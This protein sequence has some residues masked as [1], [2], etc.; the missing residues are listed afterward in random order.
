MALRIRRGTNSER[1]SIVPLEGELI[2]TTDTKDLYVGDGNTLGGVAVADMGISTL[3]QSNLVA[4]ISTY[5]LDRNVSNTSDIFV[6]VNGLIQVPTV[7]YTVAN[8]NVLIFTSEIPDES[9]LEVR[10]LIA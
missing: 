10:Y 1:Q 2:Y 3:S 8:S 6:I 4:N 5:N 9:Y 7:D